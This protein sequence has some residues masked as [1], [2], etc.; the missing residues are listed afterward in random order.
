MAQH[1]LLDSRM[2][3]T[4]LSLIYQLSEYLVFIMFVFARWGCDHEDSN[5]VVCPNCG[6]HGPHPFNQKRKQWRCKSCR[7]CFSITSNTI[8]AHRKLS[9]HDYLVAIFLF[10]CAVK[11]RAALEIARLLDTQH[12]TAWILMMKIREA[13]LLTRDESPL[14]GE[15]HID[16]AYACHYIRPQNKKI[17]RIDRRLAKNQKESKR[18]VL[19]MAQREDLDSGR[20]GAKRILTFIIKNEAQDE[21][22][23]LI[24]KYI[25][26]HSTVCCDENTAYDNAEFWVNL[27]RVCHKDEY[28][29][30]KGITNNIAEGVHARFRRLQHGQVHHFSELYID[31]Y[32][33]ESAYREVNRDKD[34]KWL[35]MDVLNRCI[36]CKPSRDFSGYWQ[37]NQRGI[38]GDPLYLPEG[39]LII[40]S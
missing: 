4:S 14:S 33:N 36:T 40:Q 31:L 19:V 8:F 7:Y 26:K 6:R 39:N 17:N 30:D 13:L 1:H 34:T 37:G 35:L 29:S 27:K 11:G 24:K 16:G 22:N 23:E 28:R 32:A 21:I 9:L 12:R 5:L 25:V 20:V 3:T 10:A 15:I 2:R 38:E 18:C